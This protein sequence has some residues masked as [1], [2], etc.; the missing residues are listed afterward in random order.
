[1]RMRSERDLTQFIDGLSVLN[2]VISQAEEIS[3]AL[4]NLTRDHPFTHH[5]LSPVWNWIDAIRWPHFDSTD[6]RSNSETTATQ[7]GLTIDTMLIDVQE[8]LKVGVSNDPAEDPATA[9]RFLTRGLS[10]VM[11]C[12]RTLNLDAI[13]S[14]LQQLLAT[15]SAVPRNEAS[16]AVGY[17]L[18]FLE[19]YLVFVDTQLINHHH[20]TNALFKLTYVSC[21]IVRGIC[22]DGFCQPPSEGEGEEGEGKESADGVGMGEGT[23]KEN[24]SEEIKEESQ[25]EGLQDTGEEGDTEREKEGDDKAVEMSQDIGGEL[26]DV[27]GQDEGENDESGDEP[28]PEDEA[29]DLD[30]ND[31]NAVDEKLWGNEQGKEPKES[32]DKLEKDHSSRQQQGNPE[33]VAKENGAKKEGEKGG[34]DQ[35][36]TA[37]SDM[38]E[39]APEVD[40]EQPG[41]QGA[42]IED[43]I[44]ETETLDLPEDLQMGED[45]VQK[46]DQDDDEDMSEGEGGVPEEEA[47]R[48]DPFPEDVSMSEE[49]P[50]ENDEVETIQAG[51]PEVTDTEDQDSNPKPALTNPDLHGGADRD[52]DEMEEPSVDTNKEDGRMGGE[53]KRTRGG[54]IGENYEE[55]MA[56]DA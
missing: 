27:E 37:D 41:A 32:D 48:Q 26:E 35:V 17:I 49:A 42:P 28:E 51:K 40:E 55:Q 44:D 24:V 53:S 56:R 10:Q 4:K 13:T 12:T 22:N 9:D 7:V 43:R 50:Q 20:W 18:P 54:Q 47:V 19:R 39:V 30:A 52:H 5:F 6:V 21:S 23:G 14:H 1:M 25:V 38:P 45:D 3:T 31:P 16:N 33:V 2:S 46:G 8:V 15:I 11:K 36:E 29:E 34:E